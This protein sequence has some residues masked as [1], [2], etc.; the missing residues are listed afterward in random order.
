MAGIL[1]TCSLQRV[2]PFVLAAPASSSDLSLESQDQTRA[3][4]ASECGGFTTGLPE[5]SPESLFIEATNYLLSVLKHCLVLKNL[6]SP[7]KMAFYIL[8]G[9]TQFFYK[10]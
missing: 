5:K 7:E 3:P 4:L 6:K 2:L 9:G 8:G 1:S 10:N